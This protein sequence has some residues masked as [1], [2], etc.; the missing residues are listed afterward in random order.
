MS[1]A[2]ET[3]M[4]EHLLILRV[5]AA[6]ETLAQRL[7]R[8]SDIPR[9]DVASFAVFF[10]KFADQCHHGKEEDRLFVRMNRFGFPTAFGPLAVML[11]E[12]TAGRGH[13]RALAAVGQGTG[14]LTAQ[15]RQEVVAL[16][17]QFVPLLRSHIQKEDNVL[18]PMAQ[19]AI[20]RDE[21]TGLDADCEAFD[22]TVMPPEA[23]QRLRELAS[24][25]IQAYPADPARFSAVFAGASGPACLGG[26][27]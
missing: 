1:K 22:R 6:L 19:Q 13:V 21:L 5:L 4:N 26:C 3:M 23:V 2:I 11:A 27:R 20:P 17:Q 16:A 24:E 7:E 14:L 10:Q 9:A 25:L 8:G 12:H 18:Y 15:E